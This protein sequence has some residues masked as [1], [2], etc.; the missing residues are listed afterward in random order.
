MNNHD[1]ILCV[2]RLSKQ[3]KSL[4]QITIRPHRKLPVAG[5]VKNRQSVQQQIIG[6]EVCEMNFIDKFLL[7]CNRHWSR[8][9]RNRNI[10]GLVQ[11]FTWAGQPFQEDGYETKG[12]AHRP[13]FSSRSP[14]SHLCISLL[15]SAVLT[16]CIL[17]YFSWRH[18]ASCYCR[19]TPSGKSSILPPVWWQQGEEKTVCSGRLKRKR[20]TLLPLLEHALA[21]LSEF[22]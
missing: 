7:I 10:K 4:C 11:G 12:D 8:C 9:L 18:S 21:Y 16:S 1:G 17:L 2:I 15:L 22:R 6:A 19:K 13:A 3:T 5:F 20:D 14:K